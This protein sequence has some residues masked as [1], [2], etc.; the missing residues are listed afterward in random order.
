MA[1]DGSSRQCCNAT[2][3][4]DVVDVLPCVPATHATRCPAIS[5]ASACERCS[6]VRPR[7]RA[8]A[9]SGFVVLDRG[10]HHRPRSARPAAGPGSRRAWPTAIRAPCCAQRRAARA[11]PWRP[12]RTPAPAGQQDPRDAAHARRRRCRP[13]APCC[14]TSR[15]G[16]GGSPG[17]TAVLI[18]AP[19]PA[20][21]GPARRPPRGG[22]CRWPRAHRRDAAR[23]RASSGM[24]GLG[25]LRR[26]QL[27]VVDHDAAARVDHRPRVERLLAVAVRQ[28]HEHRGQPD[29]G[30]LGDG[31]RA[32]AAQDHVRRRV[33]EVHPL[34]VGH[35][36]RTCGA[37]GTSCT[38]KGVLRPVGVQHADARVAELAGGAGHG[39]V[40]RARA[41]RAAGH[42]QRRRGRVQPEELRAPARA[43]PAGPAAVIAGRSGM[44]ITSAFGRPESRHGDGDPLREPRADLVGQAD[45]G[46][47]LVHD[48][49]HPAARGEVGGQR[50]VAAEA[51]HDV[52]ADPVEHLAGLLDRAAHLE[53]QLEQVDVRL[54]RHR[55]RRD[56]LQL[57][58]A[59]RDDV[60]SPGRARCPARPPCVRPQPRTASASAS[61]GSMC[62]AVPPPATTTHGPCDPPAMSRP[63]NDVLLSD[64]GWR[65]DHRRLVCASCS[66][67]R[68]RGPSA[69]RVAARGSTAVSSALGHRAPPGHARSAGRPRVAG[70]TAW[71]ACAAPAGWYG[72]GAGSRSSVPN[73][74]GPCDA[75]C[76]HR[77][78]FVAGAV[79]EH[80]RTPAW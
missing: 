43:A 79:R 49:R 19:R 35:R 9:S 7:L 53:R 18:C 67:A 39:G 68:P 28:R 15:P 51:D 32:A 4:I 46:V 27:G 50:D 11:T 8:S 71:R 69:P 63:V 2:V 70:S 54:P 76:G 57:V 58:A 34:Q 45:P 47:G 24:T 77:L 56:H 14:S 61:A 73:L 12:S 38:D 74:P 20:P 17:S 37:P 1:N 59:R 23:G 31:H 44:P 48:D 52:R 41:L 62:P 66:R 64:P 16:R 21:C 36:A 80:A 10:G 22:R 72:S 26:G 65:I 13:G 3:S 25:D 55:H 60:A 30:H 33:G 5:A 78:R 40:D 6:T 75:Q 42:Q 29:R